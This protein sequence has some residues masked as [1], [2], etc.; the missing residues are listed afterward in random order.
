MPRIP[1]PQYDA[2]EGSQRTQ[3]MPI[4]L[5]GC[6]VQLG[7]PG[8]EVVKGRYNNKELVWTRS[9]GE[10]SG[11]ITLPFRGRNTDG[12]I[13]TTGFIQTMLDDPNNNW[14]LLP[15]DK[16]SIFT[17]GSDIQSALLLNTVYGENNNSVAGVES[18]NAGV[19]RIQISA[20]TAN[21][22]VVVTP[23]EHFGYDEKTFIVNTAAQVSGTTDMFDITVLPNVDV[24]ST[25][26]IYKR[27]FL[28][29]RF[30]GN[31]TFFD[32]VNGNTAGPWNLN[33]I[34][35]NIN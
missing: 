6:S 27:I 21:D 18:V 13:K 11:S 5:E 34:E 20:V 8:R 24:P 17:K 23:G 19:W 26:V 16:P 15:W 4:E 10:F 22:T 31:Q 12:H 9:E 1:W 25:G 7:Y 29:V 3:M 2:L 30:T 33:V 32:S 35:E 28:P 14:T